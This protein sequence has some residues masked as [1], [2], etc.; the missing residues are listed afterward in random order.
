MRLRLPVAMAVAGLASFAAVLLTGGGIGAPRSA[1]AE[2]APARDTAVP[3]VRT[4]VRLIAENHYAAA[5]PLLHPSHREAAG[6]ARYVSC[7]RQSPIPGEV[8]SLRAGAATAASVSIAP[9]RRVQSRAVPV[10]VVLLDLATLERTVVRDTVNAVRVNGRWTWV[11]PPERVASYR[12]GFCPD[13]RPQ[14]PGQT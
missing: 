7:E 5:W 14:L 6:R 12:A 3:F 2:S 1:A 9:G 4:V 8:V 10:R 13:A 11:L